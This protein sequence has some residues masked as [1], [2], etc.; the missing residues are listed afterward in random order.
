MYQQDN[1]RL[2]E[3]STIAFD[4]VCY[5]EKRNGIE[6]GTTKWHG[7]NDQSR[8]EDQKRHPRYHQQEHDPEN[9]T[10]PAEIWTKPMTTR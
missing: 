2:S 3:T 7:Y 10:R 6:K 9:K 1:Q 4:A 5:R 8:V